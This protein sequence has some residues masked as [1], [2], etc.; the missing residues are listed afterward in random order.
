MAAP[1][2]LLDESRMLVHSGQVVTT[3]ALM[4][5]LDLALWLI[6]QA[7]AGKFSRVQGT[8]RRGDGIPP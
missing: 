1:V 6:R 8:I 2:A 5:H 7:S 3:G 4:G